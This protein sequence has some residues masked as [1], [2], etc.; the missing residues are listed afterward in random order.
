MSGIL[1][2]IIIYPLMQI[3]E[4]VFVAL[5][6]TFYIPGLCV[7]GVSVAVSVLCLPLYVVAEK[8]QQIERNTEKELKPGVDH[9]KET[10]KGDEQYMLLTTFYNQHHYKPVM[11]LRSS[12]GLLIQIPFFIAAYI[13]LSDVPTLHGQ[14]FL[15]IRDL[16]KQDALFSIGS[17]PV[18]VL[19]IAM[20]VVNII[21]GYIYTKGFPLKEKLQLYIMALVFLVLLYN[22]PSGL[23]LYWTMNNVFSLIKNLFYKFKNPLKVLYITCLALLAGI[24]IYLIASGTGFASCSIF[25][26][27]TIIIP[28]VPYIISR[29]RQEITLI[30]TQFSE[31]ASV[32]FTLFFFSALVMCFVTGF[33]TPSNIIT[34]S[35]QEFSFIDSYTTP[36]FFIKN[37]LLQSIGIFVFWPL[38]VYLLFSQRS[39]AVIAS[40][41]AIIALG[42]LINV[43]LFP[44]HYGVMSPM[45]TFD[46]AEGFKV[47]TP[48]VLLNIAVLILPWIF[49]HLMLK[50]QKSHF[51][52]GIMCLFAV[53]LAGTSIYNCYNIKRSFNRLASVYDNEQHDTVDPVFHLSKTGKNVFVIMLDRAVNGYIPT[54]FQE[55]PDLKTSYSG[56]TYY[57]N[58]V[59]F[60]FFTIQGA[61]PLYGGYEYTPLEMNKRSKEPLVK[62][63]DE[64]LSVLPRLF[65]QNGYAATMADAPW[66][67]FSWISDMSFMNDYPEKI[68]TVH[69][70]K[71]YKAEWYK[72][73]NTEMPAVQSALDKRNFIWVGIMKD[74]P[75]LL[76]EAVYGDGNWWAVASPESG[77]TTFLDS[78]S[79]LDF[80][81]K[82]TDT[83]AT[84]NTFT[85][86]DNDTTHD[87]ALC[88]APDYVPVPKVTYRGKT[89]FA[90]DLHYHANAAAIHRLAVWL[91]YL[92]KEG[93]YDNTRII[94]ASDHGRNVKT[95]QFE[96]ERKLPFMREYCHPYLL[97][98]DF[99]AS[100]EI[101]TDNTF[102]TNADA[103][104]LAVKDIIA[105]PVNPF[106]GNKIT[107]DGKKNLVTITSSKNWLPS[108]QNKNTLAVAGTDWFTVHDNIFNEKNWRPVKKT[109]KEELKR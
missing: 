18:N 58:T 8:W 22:S 28:F 13:F 93:V 63:Y 87:P 59:S 73:H 94:I 25:I 76:R 30:L 68:T 61:P 85:F 54:I 53:G 45:L 83:T 9:I 109:L 88:Q 31:H 107:S 55:D 74:L 2:T 34:S 57:P 42:A 12:F 105:N 51:L 106:T 17:F 89:A 92:K 72:M 96:K 40:L 98:K 50:Y 19:P 52:S 43:F 70:M 80:L 24:D 46:S 108:Q 62:K 7:I 14:S 37:T 103:P 15:F 33:L 95:N 69:T 39:R 78:Y 36:M 29:T 16:G 32:C 3:I 6:G 84:T 27:L 75:F 35:P 71:K 44:G 64:A 11:A 82:L 20:T 79:V 49:V 86:M 41:S 23:V 81:P 38:M 104:T 56:F 48:I 21:A 26:A 10:F 101:Q 66:G 90:D 91:D 97:F 60:G 5:Q 4:L 47:R 99:N 77:N 67:N 102:M 100:G 1:Y 65:A